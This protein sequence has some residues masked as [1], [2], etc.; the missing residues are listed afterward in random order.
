MTKK[1]DGTKTYIL[2]LNNGNMRR[3]EVPASWKLTF[4]PTIPYTGKNGMVPVSQGGTAL[5][6]YEG[7]KENLRAVFTDVR[8]FRDSSVPVMEKRTETQKK[9]IKK[10]S[11][12]GMHDVHVEARVTEWVNPDDE[13]GAGSNDKAHPYLLAMENSGEEF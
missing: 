4:G 9:V 8:A 1:T 10:A 7:N 6:F 11:A 13:T 12:G 2:D 5:R 3:V